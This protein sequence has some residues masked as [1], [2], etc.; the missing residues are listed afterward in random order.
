MNPVD[1][2]EALHIGPDPDKLFVYHRQQLSAMLDGELSPDE[3][4]FMLR[5]LQHD[6]ELAACWER[7]QVGGDVLRGRHNDL[8]PGD[9][10]QRVAL[11]LA[12]GSTVSVEI[13]AATRGGRPRFARWGGGAAIAASVALLAVFATRQL[14]E[15]DE[16]HQEGAAAP[17]V[18]EASTPP[19]SIALPAVQPA[20]AP[21]MADAEVPAAPATPLRDASAALAATALAAAEVP[22]RVS[23]RRARTQPRPTSG[24]VQAASDLPA[25]VAVAA[26]DE[27]VPG[28]IL[29]PGDL[30][31]AGDPFAMPQTASARPWPRSLLPSTSAAYTVAGGGLAPR[32]QEFEPFM[33]GHRS[34]PW[35]AT[36]SPEPS[37]TPTAQP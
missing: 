22:R 18:A 14:P 4:K 8:L 24:R 16:L 23:E 5:R 27:S 1:D 13:A 30:A 36:E 9:F 29:L 19:P 37:G 26:N 21:A 25:P 34:A 15:P 3:A 2:N 17:L 12:A 33:P 6:T 31:P 7:W 32:E 10:A 11:A 35:P 20:A 28:S